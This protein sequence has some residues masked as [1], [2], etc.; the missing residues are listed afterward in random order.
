ME[1][2][3]QILNP[4]LSNKLKYHR[5]PLHPTP[6]QHPTTT[7]VPCNATQGQVSARCKATTICRRRASHLSW[8]FVGCCTSHGYL[9]RVHWS[10]VSTPKYPGPGPRPLI[11]CAVPCWTPE[12]ETYLQK[13]FIYISSFL[14]QKS[15]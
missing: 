15:Y 14:A 2:P 7:P 8:I 12:I 1:F 3:Q 4:A 5:G 10:T 13:E 9:Q 11:S 6:Q